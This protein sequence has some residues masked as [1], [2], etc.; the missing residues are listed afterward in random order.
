MLKKIPLLIAVLMLS[1]CASVPDSLKVAEGQQLVTYQQVMSNPQINVGKNARWGGVIASVENKADSTLL[2]IVHHDL[3]SNGRP[4]QSDQSVGRFRVYVDSFLD[5][6]IYQTGRSI[7]FVGQVKGTESGLVGEHKYTYPA[8]QAS[9]YYMWD[10]RSQMNVTSVS[11]SMWPGSY[12]GGWYGWGYRGG[13]WPYHQRV[14]I[15]DNDKPGTSGPQ[16]VRP[17]VNTNPRVEQPKGLGSNKH[18]AD[19]RILD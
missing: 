1:A 3:K 12:W 17:R 13:I 2:E 6:M 18:H 16:P 11:M 8:L 14:I 15:R 10:V 5:P 19:R 7:S 9:S 4:A